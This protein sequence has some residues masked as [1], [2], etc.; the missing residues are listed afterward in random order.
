MVSTVIKYFPPYSSGYL[1]RYGVS[2]SPALSS[3][4]DVM[5]NKRPEKV[6]SQ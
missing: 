3:C 6:V 5:P 2:S 1:A 4:S